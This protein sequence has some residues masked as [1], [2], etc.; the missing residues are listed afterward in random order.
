M[1]INKLNRPSKQYITTQH[2]SAWKLIKAYWQSEFRTS[3]YLFL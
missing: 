3:A 2:Y 1:D